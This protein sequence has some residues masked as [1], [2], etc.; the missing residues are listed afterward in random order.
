MDGGHTFN[1]DIVALYDNLQREHVTITLRIAM[2]EE[3]FNWSDE[4][5]NWLML[6]PKI[7][8]QYCK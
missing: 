3:R 1:A 2:C 6:I 7:N 4:F 8:L 5:G